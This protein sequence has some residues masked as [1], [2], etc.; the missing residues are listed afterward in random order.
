M[1][2]GVKRAAMPL[3]NFDQVTKFIGNVG[4]PAAALFF[5]LGEHIFPLF[6]VGVPWIDLWHCPESA[7]ARVLTKSRLCQRSALGGLSCLR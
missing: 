5:V 6:V 1:T 7:T 2:N 3:P 4:V